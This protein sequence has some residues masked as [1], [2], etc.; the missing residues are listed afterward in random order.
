MTTTADL[1]PARFL[2]TPERLA[3]ALS[4]AGLQAGP[5]SGFK[6][7][8]VVNDPATVLRGAHLLTTQGALAP[9]LDSTLQVAA[10]PQRVLTGLVIFAG[11]QA[12]RQI[13]FVQGV[14]DNPVVLHRRHEQGW[15]LTLLPSSAQAIV[16]VDDLLSL[17]RLPA[18]VG[19]DAV[20]LD[21]PGYGAIL[22]AADALQAARLAAQAGRSRVLP[23]LLTAP[24]LTE[25]LEKGLGTMDTRW[26]VT[27]ARLVAP[28]DLKLVVRQ[29]GAG[30]EQLQRSGLARAVRGG[31][32]LTR[33]GLGIAG[34]L[35]Y[36]LNAGGF[37]HISVVSGQESTVATINLFRTMASIW[38]A[39]WTNVEATGAKLRLMEVSAG[40]A[41]RV[42]A[43][44]LTTLKQQDGG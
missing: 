11:S 15:D 18:Q 22:A 19:D 29:M 13:S 21:L 3:A 6:E 17:S 16:L 24:L 7:L 5:R 42:V 2:L 44:M 37:V 26:A 9:D 34:P 1:L 35:G 25:Q 8:P 4:V 40:G 41:L 14:E 20:E 30:L 28:L 36:L 10:D 38:L 39:M 32:E 23:T 31:H 43:G 27:A 12:L 33:E